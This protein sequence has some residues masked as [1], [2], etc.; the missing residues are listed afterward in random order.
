MDPFMDF[1]PL[2]RQKSG[3]TSCPKCKKGY[4][5]RTVPE[6]CSDKNCGA[7]VGGSYKHKEKELDAQMIT[8]SIVSVRQNAT[9]RPLR[10]FVDLKSRKVFVYIKLIE[11]KI[12][13]W[14]KGI[15]YKR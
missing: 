15:F 2:K 3:Q 6:F 1:Q 9:G 12:I 8:S 13:N 5:N 11:S 7:R 10:V 4:N 14:R